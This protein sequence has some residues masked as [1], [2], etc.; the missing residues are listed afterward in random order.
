MS[1]ELVTE[2]LLLACIGG[3]LGL[4]F[5]FLRWLR[6][7]SPGLEKRTL[8]HRCGHSVGL[9]PRNRSALRIRAGYA[10]FTTSE[11]LAADEQDQ[12]AR[13]AT[14]LRGGAGCLLR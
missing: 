2:S 11:W 14:C 8:M 1:P 5:P 6:M 3:A 12:F 4:P 9:I 13:D 10:N 7:A